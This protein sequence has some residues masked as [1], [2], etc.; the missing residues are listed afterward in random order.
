MNLQQNYRKVV[1]NSPWPLVSGKYYYPYMPSKYT[2][3]KRNAGYY[4]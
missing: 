4:D 2:V 1:T 3:V